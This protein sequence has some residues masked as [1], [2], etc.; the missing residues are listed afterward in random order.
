MKSMNISSATG[1][2]PVVAA[3]T[4]MPTRPVSLIGVS[5]TRPAPY[6]PMRPFV[7]PITPPQASSFWPAPPAMSSPSTMTVGSAAIA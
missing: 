3:P 7:A 1:R 2:K 5:I 4:A 6:L